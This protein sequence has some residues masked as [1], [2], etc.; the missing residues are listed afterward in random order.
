M[1]ATA[2]CGCAAGVRRNSETL[3]EL[4]PVIKGFVPISSIGVPITTTTIAEG[5]GIKTFLVV[6]ELRMVLVLVLLLEIKIA[7]TPRTPLI[8]S[9]STRM[10]TMIAP[11]PRILL[12]HSDSNSC[13]AKGSPPAR[14]TAEARQRAKREARPKLFLNLL[15]ASCPT[16]AGR[17]L[18]LNSYL[19]FE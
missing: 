12:I 13:E 1:E 6:M 2:W 19:I 3:E 17:G 10:V 4:R 5:K 16:A 15:K 14:P 18:L 8:L 11:T 9:D 7:P